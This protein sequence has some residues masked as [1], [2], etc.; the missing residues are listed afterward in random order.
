MVSNV[1]E[2]AAI[3][4]HF[5]VATTIHHIRVLALRA[6]VPGLALE[7]LLV[8]RRCAVQL[9]CHAMRDGYTWYAPDSLVLIARRGRIHVRLAHPNHH[10]HCVVALRAAKA[11]HVHVHD[12]R[13]STAGTD[14]LR[15]GLHRSATERWHVTVPTRVSIVAVA[16]AVGLRPPM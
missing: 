11:A 3:A 7:A 1:A 12:A 15:M 8:R 9:I 5:A 2:A 6:C 13:G 14:G 4:A 10:I 16:A